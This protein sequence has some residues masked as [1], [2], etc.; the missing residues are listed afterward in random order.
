MLKK[1]I[2]GLFQHERQKV[3]FLLFFIFQTLNGFEKAQYFQRWAFLL[4]LKDQAALSALCDPASLEG[5]PCRPWQGV[6]ASASRRSP[7]VRPLGWPKVQRSSGLIRLAHV[8]H[9]GY[10]KTAFFNS[11]PIPHLSTRRADRAPAP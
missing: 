8:P 4:R 7:P 5:Q 6:R 11:L 3:R 2:H 1:S 9:A 10:R